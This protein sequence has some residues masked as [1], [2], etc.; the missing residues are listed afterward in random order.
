LNLVH[1]LMLGNSVEVI[2]VGRAQYQPSAAC[3]AWRNLDGGV[4]HP[5]ED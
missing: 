5:C 2:E 1:S 3:D 4:G